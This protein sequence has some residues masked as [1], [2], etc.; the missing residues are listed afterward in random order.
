MPGLADHIARIAQDEALPQRVEEA[1]RQTAVLPVLDA[2][3]WDCWDGNEV[4]PEFEVRGGRVDY[5]LQVPGQRLVLIEVKRTGTDLTGHQEQLLR[6]AFDEGVPLAALTDGRVWW[7]YLSTAAGNWE[8]RRFFSIDFR[9]QEAAAAA[10][11]LERFLSRK[12]VASGTA[13]REAQREFESQERDRRV[14]AALQDAWKQ[15]LGDPDGLL[16]DLLAETV[17]EISGHQPDPETV[18]GF[19]QGISGSGSAEAELPVPPPRTEGR[20]PRRRQ[21][22]RSAAAAPAA[23]ASE[24]GSSAEMTGA[25]TPTS[26]RGRRVA[27]FLLDGGR[28]EV[29]SWPHL[30]QALSDQVAKEAGAAFVEHVANVRGRTRVY[31]SEHP[32]DLQH[33]RELTNSTLY[34]EGNVGPDRA[35]RISRRVL[36]AVRGSD[37]G[38]GIEL[39]GHMAPDRGHGSTEA[40]VNAPSQASFTG[41]RPAAFW[42]GSGRYEVRSWRELLPRVCGQ[43]L[44]EVGP[45]F[46]QRIAEQQGQ[47]YFRSSPPDSA[48]WVPIADTGRHVYVNITAD[49]A[50]DRSRRVVRAVRGSD[51]GFHIELADEAAS[52]LEKTAVAPP[53]VS[54]KGRSPAAFWLDGNRYEAARWNEVLRGICERLATEAGPAFAERVVHLRG[55]RRPYFSSSPSDLRVPLQVPGADLYAEGNFSANDC[56]RHARRV[57][58]A[59]R[60]TDDGFDIELAE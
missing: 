46:V 31:F 17:K 10:A 49:V 19:L 20:R 21:A 35:A 58:N 1:A 45:A 16:R 56:V 13:L 52:P 9:Q 26:F 3:G 38:F 32:D 44:I 27:A 24:A 41:R 29:K 54:F 50:V 28:H 7:L 55:R 57:L 22:G 53:S 6:Y 4:T 18:A 34:V 5:C 36:I 42:L 33:P 40:A 11:D 8:Q 23:P 51:D 48:D 60:G 59:V 14:R 15:V 12:G 37:E 30:V 43:L 2:L 39:R 25:P 47:P